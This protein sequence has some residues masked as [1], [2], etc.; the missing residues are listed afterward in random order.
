M[1]SL[2]LFAD[3]QS[4]DALM[5]I[6]ALNT[7]QTRGGRDIPVCLFERLEDALAFG[8]LAGLLK[9]RS[10]RGIRGKPHFKRHSG[11]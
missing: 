9:L 7:E 1:K 6:G 3:A 10:G 4:A 8:G 2:I 11:G 5:K